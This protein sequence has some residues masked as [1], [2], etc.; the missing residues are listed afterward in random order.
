MKIYEEHKHKPRRWTHYKTS[1]RW[2]IYLEGGVPVLALVNT[3]AVGLGE[4][5][6]GVQSGHGSGELGHGVEVGGEVVEHRHHV[7]RELST[8]SPVLGETSHLVLSGNISS[9]QQPEQ[10]LGQRLLTS[11]SLGEQL[12]ALGDGV[13]TEPDALVSVQ[14]RGLGDQALH[15]PHTSVDLVHGDLA[16]L[17]VPVRLPEGLHLLLDHGDLLREDRLEIRGIAGLR[18]RLRG[19]SQQFLGKFSIN[20]KIG[21]TK[22]AAKELQ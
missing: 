10:T 7:G 12:L 1:E 22:M 5:G 21:N 15:A 9:Q 18:D 2:D 3:L 4:L 13:A 16:N 6:L 14:D 8:T 19:G 17:G 11:G 20:Y